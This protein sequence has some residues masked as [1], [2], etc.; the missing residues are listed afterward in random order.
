MFAVN[1][2]STFS[3]QTLSLDDR[4]ATPFG[5]V[6]SA[7]P[8]GAVFSPDGRWVAYHSNPQRRSAPKSNRG[9]FVQPFPPTGARYQIP[10][11]RNI[12]HPVWRPD[13]AALFYIA[14]AGRL[15]EVSL[16]TGPSFTFGRTVDLPGTLMP[17]SRSSEVRDYDI[18]PDGRFIGFVAG[19]D[20]SGNAG[21]PEIRLVL[22]WF[23]E[24]RQRVPVR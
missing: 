17:D 23:E 9:L 20:T 19:Q 24:L 8:I 12:F 10:S 16:Q 2:D 1:K 11:S 13:R 14:G 15:A 5:E 21:E 18:L 4:K 6:L 22:N 7:E 3:L